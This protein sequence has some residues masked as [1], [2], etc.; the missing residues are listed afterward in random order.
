MDTDYS[1]MCSELIESLDYLRPTVKRTNRQ[2]G[3]ALNLES[4][5]GDIGALKHLSAKFSKKAGYS[6]TKRR[7]AE[8]SSSLIL[9]KTTEREISENSTSLSYTG[10]IGTAENERKPLKKQIH[11][12][13]EKPI[14]KV[15]IIP[16]PVQT[17]TSNFLKKRKLIAK[18]IQ[19]TVSNHENSIQAKNLFLVLGQQQRDLVYELKR[20]GSAKLVNKNEQKHKDDE[21]SLDQISSLKLVL[22][23]LNMDKRKDKNRKKI[24]RK[25]EANS[26]EPAGTSKYHQYDFR[27]CT[28]PISPITAKSEHAGD[29]N[30]RKSCVRIT[31]RVGLTEDDRYV[32]Q[33]A[34]SIDDKPA[35]TELAAIN[36]RTHRDE[37]RFPCSRK[38]ITDNCVREG[39]A[40]NFR[41]H[42]NSNNQFD[43]LNESP[44]NVEIQSTNPRCK[45]CSCCDCLDC[46]VNNRN[47][48]ATVDKRD[49]N[50]Q[51]D[52][53]ED[54]SWESAH[55]ASGSPMA[56]N[57]LKCQASHGTQVN[58]DIGFTNT[59]TC[60][61]ISTI[62]T[63]K[64]KIIQYSCINTTTDDNEFCEEMT[65][66][67]ECDR[68]SL[69]RS[70]S[71]MVVISVY[72]IQKMDG[73]KVKVATKPAVANKYFSYARNN[74]VE[75]QLNKERQ[76][77]KN[78]RK[79]RSVNNCPNIS[80]SRSP[81]PQ[82]RNQSKSNLNDTKVSKTINNRKAS[83]IHDRTTSPPNV[84]RK[85][86]LEKTKYNKEQSKSWTRPNRWAQK[87][88]KSTNTEHNVTKKLLVDS[89]TKQLTDFL[90]N[91]KIKKY[92]NCK[93]ENDTNVQVNIDGSDQCYDVTFCQGRKV[94]DNRRKSNKIKNSKPLNDSPSLQNLLIPEEDSNNRS[95]SKA[96]SNDQQD[97]EGTF[98]RLQ[99][100]DSLEISHRREESNPFNAWK[101]E[102]ATNDGEKFKRNSPSNKHYRGDSCP[103][104]NPIVR[105]QEIR[106]LLG[107]D[108]G[109]EKFSSMV[110]PV[111]NIIAQPMHCSYESTC[112]KNITSLPVKT[113]NQPESCACTDIANAMKYNKTTNIRDTIPARLWKMRC[114]CKLSVGK[115][116]D[117]CECSMNKDGQKDQGTVTSQTALNIT[118]TNENQQIQCCLASTRNLSSSGKD[119]QCECSMSSSYDQNKIEKASVKS[120]SKTSILINNK[121]TQHGET[122][123]PRT[124]LYQQLILNRNIQV[125]LQVEQFSKQKPIILSRKQ[126]NKVK[127]TIEN[128]II[129]K[130]SKRKTCICKTSLLSL[131]EVKRK[132]N[133]RKSNLDNKE[134]ETQRASVSDESKKNNSSEDLKQQNT[135]YLFTGKQNSD[136]EH[137]KTP[138]KT[139]SSVEF[140]FA[141]V[142][143]T[144]Y[145]TFSSTNVEVGTSASRFGEQQSPSLHTIFKSHRKCASPNLGTSLYSLNSEGDTLGHEPK[146]AEPRIEPKAKKP[147]LRRLMSCLVLRSAKVTGVS[148][149]INAVTRPF[150]EPSLDSSF[151]SYHISSAFCGVEMTSS[152]YDTSI[153]FYSNHSVYP[154]NSK[155]KRGFFN[156]VREFLSIRKSQS[157]KAKNQ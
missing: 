130:K 11:G 20:I 138:R 142:S 83:P 124:S 151:D 123:V 61:N 150:N 105:D 22:D 75:T 79:S 120:V 132:T 52:L 140:R 89:Y 121:A 76:T 97:N 86:N 23:S 67:S 64:D 46:S 149:E 24:P 94:T 14:V 153:S 98:S 45:L 30:S 6:K 131:G 62:N 16:K 157:L 144:K 73:E 68:N 26:P 5:K 1:S 39:S 60:D 141:S 66:D 100:K 133:H 106:A 112:D 55:Q 72:P 33:Y 59:V 148:R 107:V 21:V 48:S 13:V 126:Y 50:I 57:L 117:I 54:R 110:Y 92:C 15:T 118:T 77:S 129:S 4:S 63:V 127:R 84:N 35:N 37:Q 116:S 8:S 101:S 47:V 155:M 44:K 27:E 95:I 34:A 104:S 103:L 88:T 40:R 29:L 9:E 53:P 28:C 87:E 78:S 145:V 134:A 43:S 128:T 80:R 114:E 99:V 143:C 2:I 10:L 102:T 136:S 38:C 19:A 146:N 154:V 56:P 156:S 7:G 122:H 90:Q 91:N 17:Q 111:Y 82:T 108:K 115:R 41:T 137:V 93:R 18:K 74:H 81:S 69:K 25:L 58:F 119:V 96:V 32:L 139:A 125:F 135:Y 113:E 31:G 49:H 71:P 36:F 85:I 147:F 12:A 65:S 152:M 3:S 42:R 51:V 109:R 70:P